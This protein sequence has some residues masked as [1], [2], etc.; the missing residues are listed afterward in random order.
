MSQQ[1]S[2][3][4][5]LEELA[6]RTG[7]TP[8]QLLRWRTRRLIGAEDQ[9]GFGPED[10]ESVRLIQL[11]FRRGI[12][13]ETIARAE[14]EEQGFLRHYVDQLFP[15]G[16]GP[17][18]SVAEA[19]AMVGLDVELV[20]RLQEVSGSP[21]SKER[22]DKEDVEILRGWKVALEA[23]LPEEALFQ[24]VRV[25][26]DALGRVAEAEARLFHFYVHERLR[27]GGLS[28]LELHNAT[29]AASRPMRQLIEP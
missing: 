24:L 13:A 4:L 9:E 21:G 26:A 2:L 16:I 12:N 8:E 18:Y 20:C 11:S 28:G 25:Y 5:S 15:A 29:E 7:E 17:T 10:V 14:A 22:L 3:G 6:K 1:R 19:A 23:G 27:D